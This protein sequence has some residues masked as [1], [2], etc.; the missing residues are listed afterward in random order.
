[1]R[2]GTGRIVRTGGWWTVVQIMRTIW[3]STVIR[4]LNWWSS[5]KLMIEDFQVEVDYVTSV[6]I[7]V[8]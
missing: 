7:T 6:G 8:V 5:E 3:T 1:M 4:G 2:W